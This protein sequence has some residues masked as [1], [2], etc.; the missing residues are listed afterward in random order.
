MQQISVEQDIAEGTSVRRFMARRGAIVV[1]ETRDIGSVQGIYSDKIL[2]AAV[3]IA[4]VQHGK[5]EMSYGVQLERVAQDR[6]TTASVFLDF[7]ELG[8]LK[9]ALDFISATAKDFG[10]Q[11]RDYTEITYST[12]DRARLGF[13]QDKNGN[14]QAFVELQPHSDM[15]FFEL[16]ELTRL[17]LVLEKGKFHLESR[18]AAVV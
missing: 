11:Q 13:Y 9:D 16:D 18:G 10:S 14:Q 17:K 6:N 1:K 15:S 2:L 8:E 5:R 7:E 4:V 3:V 12:R